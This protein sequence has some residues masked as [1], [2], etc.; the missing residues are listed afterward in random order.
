MNIKLKAALLTVRIIAL[1][2]FFT[3]SLV[4]SFVYIPLAYIGT[5]VLVVFFCVSVYGLYSVTLQDLIDHE[6]LKEHLGRK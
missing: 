4:A 3:L 6:K 5:A 2:V 1:T